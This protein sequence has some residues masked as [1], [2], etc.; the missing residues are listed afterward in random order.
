MFG[1][2]Q[3]GFLIVGYQALRELFVKT[4]PKAADKKHKIIKTI[5]DNISWAILPQT[6]T[7]CNLIKI[8]EGHNIRTL[9][10]FYLLSKENAMLPS[11][12]ISY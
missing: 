1:G 9:M 3:D 6:K 7:P 12:K 4:V 5:N 11:F 10:K 2:F 8:T